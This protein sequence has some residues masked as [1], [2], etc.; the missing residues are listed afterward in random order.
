MAETI[1]SYKP[2]EKTNV[3]GNS[4]VTCEVELGTEYK[5]GGFVLSPTEC[6]LT[7]G[8][9]VSGYVNP[10]AKSEAGGFF[11][12]IIEGTSTEA[13]TV[14]LAA[15]VLGTAVAAKPFKE[16]ASKNEELKEQKVLVTLVGR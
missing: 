5:T 13:Q 1:K 3:G 14:K 16:P 11:S 2:K 9:V 15:Y 6:G 4:L 12:L 8:A 7:T 10:I